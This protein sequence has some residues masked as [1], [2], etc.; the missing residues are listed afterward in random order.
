MEKELLNSTE[1]ENTLA[2]LAFQ[3]IEKCSRI[4]EICIVGVK[5]RGEYLAL[6]LK[7][8]I[9]KQKGVSIPF[10]SLDITLYRDD[11]SEIAESPKLLGSLISFD[12]RKKA[13]ILVDDV[14]YTGRT[15]RAAMDALTDYGRPGRIVFVAL[16]DR[17]HR[18]LPIQPDFVGKV[19]PTS[20]DEIIHVKLTEVDGQDSVTIA[21]II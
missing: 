11:L 9:E 1:L 8:L 3:I 14:V 13:V 7:E 10:G 12:V 20:A 2:R 4:E 15:V 21:R 5:R 19:V 16:I 18:E 6:R 17:G